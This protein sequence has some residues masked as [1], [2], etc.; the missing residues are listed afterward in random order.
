MGCCLLNFNPS[1][2]F[3]LNRVQ[4]SCS[5][6]VSLF[7]RAFP[8]VVTNPPPSRWREYYSPTQY[9]KEPF[10]SSILDERHTYAAV[11][12]VENNPVRAGLVNRAE[13]YRWSSARE[14]IDK[15]SGGNITT[16]CFLTEEISSWAPYLGGKENET[17]LQDIRKKAMTGR[18]CGD[19]A[20]IEKL[21][22]KFSYRL[23]ALP[24]G[25][26]RSK[27]RDNK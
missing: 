11:R 12:Y 10:F 17:I 7:L 1:I 16:E 22:Q 13:D 18:P 14:H 24:R 2:C 20:F 15:N 26:H 9:K 3:I 8:N 23:R 6:S 27:T 21:E 5:A 25:R 4:S 19:T